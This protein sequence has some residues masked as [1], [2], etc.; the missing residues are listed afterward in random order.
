[1]QIPLRKS[2][3]SIGKIYF[4][5]ATIHNW[6]PLLETDNN[7][8]IIIDIISEVTGTPTTV[9]CVV[10]KASKPTKSDKVVAAAIPT[11]FETISNI[12]GSIEVLES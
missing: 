7:K 1:M 2:T 6:L 9:V 8:Q 4:W 11:H 12:F 3:T 10:D 5:T